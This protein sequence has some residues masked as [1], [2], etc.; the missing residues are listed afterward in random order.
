[1]PEEDQSATAP[2]TD[3][4]EIQTADALESNLQDLVNDDPFS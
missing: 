3:E 1:M 2:L 4:P